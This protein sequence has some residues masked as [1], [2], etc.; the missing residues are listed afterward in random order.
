LVEQIKIRFVRA[1]AN[2]PER[3]TGSFLSQEMKE[4]YLA[5]LDDRRKRL[6]LE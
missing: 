3:I 2:W 5:L 6:G 4:R 1:S